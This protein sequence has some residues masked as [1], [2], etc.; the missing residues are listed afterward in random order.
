MKTSI[1]ILL[2]LIA[3]TFSYGL[4]VNFQLVLESNEIA[5]TVISSKEF[6]GEPNHYTFNVKKG[7]GVNGFIVRDGIDYRAFKN[8][9]N[10]YFPKHQSW[11]NDVH[12]FSSLCAKMG[13]NAV[14]NNY[15]VTIN[16]LDDG[17]SKLVYKLYL[18]K[19]D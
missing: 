15:M 4:S 13:I 10:E 9:L 14:L 17:G 3:P 12:D 18:Y 2:S 7:E 8:V 6:N 5:F 1:L 16:E 19:P 11:I